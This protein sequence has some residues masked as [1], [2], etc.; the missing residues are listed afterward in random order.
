MAVTW[1]KIAYEDD[2]PLKSVLTAKGSIYGASGASTPA[3]LAVGTNG[4]LLAAL[5]TEVTGLVWKDPTT[6]AVA[7]HEATHKNAG[8]DEIL[9]N[10]FGEPTAAVPFDGQQATNLVVHTVADAAG[11]PTAAVGK[12]CW[13]TDTLA[14]Y[15]CTV[16]V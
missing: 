3:E 14:L 1:K 13:Q 9:L 6:L 8:S 10:E 2:V 15:A 5:S 7:L 4:Y 11:R 12:V 16:A